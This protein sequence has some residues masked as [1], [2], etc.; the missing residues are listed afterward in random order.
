MQRPRPRENP[1]SSRVPHS[2]QTAALIACVCIKSG[3]APIPRSA[4]GQAAVCDSPASRTIVLRVEA[5]KPSRV[6]SEPTVAGM[7]RFYPVEGKSASLIRE[8]CGDSTS[9]RRRRKSNHAELCAAIAKKVTGTT[10]LFVLQ[11]DQTPRPSG[12]GSS[13]GSYFG[14]SEA[15][16]FSKRGSP[17]SGSQNGNSFK[18]P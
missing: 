11:C 18:A 10:A 17:R 3:T 12:A 15:T 2:G 16:I 9:G 14:A 7:R 4:P 13:R 6:I 8:R 1:P 5:N